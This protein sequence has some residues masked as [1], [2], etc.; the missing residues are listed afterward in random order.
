MGIKNLTS[1]L[2]EHCPAGI[3]E[4]NLNELSGKKTA[5]D[6]S[7]FLYKFKYKANRLIPKFL[8]QINRLCI[9][10]ITPIY[11]FDGIP[12]EEKK[13]VIISRQNKL[14]EKKEIIDKLKH[15]I[16]T[17]TD[18]EHKTKLKIDLYKLDNKMIHVTKE[19]IQ[20]VKYLFDLL[21]IKYIQAEGEA[22]LLCSKM[23][24]K[25]KV[26][27]VISEDM[28]L[29]TSGTNLLLRDFNIYN[30]RATLYDLN[31]IM[32]KLEVSYEQF[33][34]LCIMLGC[35]YLK[36]PNGMGPKKSFKLIKECS[37]IDVIVSK[38]V[39]KNIL[40]EDDYCDK[41]KKAKQIFMNYN[42][43]YCGDVCVNIDALFD[44]Q[45]DNIKIFLNKYTGLSE[46]QISNRI[47]NIYNI[48]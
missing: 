36:R 4:I 44:N 40:L 45:I 26:D 48:I 16:A 31:E 14:K 9:N 29:L 24:S 47:Y 6:T 33:V 39:E 1:F 10:N 43:D 18:I 19:D 22:D 28:D 25:G 42:M 7:I 15:E 13:E 8:E 37:S 21:N 17:T 11:I 32:T 5:I 27:F 12:P 35:D 30:N 46:K 23:C 34:D 20:Q 2:Q 38:M 3:R 41:F